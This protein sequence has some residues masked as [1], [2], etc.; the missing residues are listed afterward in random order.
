M[1]LL[2]LLLCSVIAVFAESFK[3]I[4]IDLQ[5]SFYIQK[6]NRQ[7]TLKQYAYQ[8]SIYHNTSKPFFSASYCVYGKKLIKFSQKVDKPKYKMC[9]NKDNTINIY[10]LSKSFRH[11]A[12]TEYNVVIKAINLKIQNKHT[13]QSCNAEVKTYKQLHETINKCIKNEL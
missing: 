11:V 8:F 13:Q 5:A 4:D 10:S 12:Q 6:Q 3:Q 7:S 1:K 2:L 9:L